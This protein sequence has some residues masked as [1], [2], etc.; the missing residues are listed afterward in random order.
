MMAAL[1]ECLMVVSISE[2]TKIRW[3]LM[4]KMGAAR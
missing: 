3:A 2:P 4:M 1:N